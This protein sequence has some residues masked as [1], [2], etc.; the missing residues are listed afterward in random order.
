MLL[1]LLSSNLGACRSGI[2][3]SRT[4]VLGE[5]DSVI[6]KTLSFYLCAAHEFSFLLS[7]AWSTTWNLVGGLL[8]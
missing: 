2:Y 5:S 4:E 6:E 8:Q 7:G 3:G 1:G